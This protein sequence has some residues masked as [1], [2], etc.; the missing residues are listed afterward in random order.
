MKVLVTGGAGYLGSIIVRKLLH[1][2]YHVRV[3]DNLLYGD[4]SIREILSHQDFEM[5]FGDIRDMRTLVKAINGVDAVIH[6]AAIVGDQA[7]DLDSKSTIEINYLA[8]KNI[9]ELCSLYG[10]EK[11]LFASSCTVYGAQPGEVLTEESRPAPFSLYGETKFKSENAI[12][13]VENLSPTILRMGT[14]YGLS[15]RMRFDLA[16]NLFIA[17]AIQEEKI[18]VFG[19]NQNRP[20][21]HVDDAANAFLMAIEKDGNGLFNVGG[22]NTSILDVAKKIKK[23][24]PTVDIEINPEI[25]DKRDYMIS[26][27]KI[28]RTLEFK[29]KKAIKDAILEIK[30]AYVHGIIK[31]YTLSEYR[32]Y[33]FLFSSPEVQ[34]KV[35][36]LG[37]IFGRNK[38][39]NNCHW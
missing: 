25:K 11:F 36:T 39:G 28:K 7:G 3:L 27:S 15:P 6:L 33:E 12:L 35:Y 21:L 31:D 38:D 20:F 16:V 34:S 13:S 37:P 9:A 10:V 22:E 5:I 8:T 19:G 23:Y 30:N 26:S 29:N 1:L 17:K 14:L 2:G 24:I 18:T 32:N 4:N